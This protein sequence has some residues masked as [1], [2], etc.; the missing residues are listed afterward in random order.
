MDIESYTNKRLKE[1]IG[2]WVNTLDKSKFIY[3]QD[4][5]DEIEA[6]WDIKPYSILDLTYTRL[7]RAMRELGYHPHSTGKRRGWLIEVEEKN[8]N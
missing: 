2:E 8:V 3:S 4:L 5:F 1:V 7:G 6:I